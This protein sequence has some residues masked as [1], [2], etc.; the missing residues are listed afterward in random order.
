LKTA[1][2]ISLAAAVV[3][4]TLVV[5]GATSIAASDRASYSV[6]LRS[7]VTNLAAVAQQQAARFGGS[8]TARVHAPAEGLLL[9]LPSAAVSRLAQEPQVA[10]VEPDGV[11]NGDTTQTGATWG[12]DR[13]DQRSLPLSGTYTYFATGSGVKAYVIDTGIRYTHTQF[14]GRAIKGVDEVTSGGTAADCNGHGTHVSGTVGGSTYGVS[15]R[16]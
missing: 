1:A 11:M 6:V 10:Y 3:V 16:V 2:R 14:G 13:I 4:A 8:V 7:S 9:T 12:I 15:R 5:F